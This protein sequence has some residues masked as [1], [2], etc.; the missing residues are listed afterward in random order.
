MDFSD[1]GAFPK[2]RYRPVAD[3]SHQAKISSSAHWKESMHSHQA[4]KLGRCV[5]RLALAVAVIAPAIQDAEATDIDH[6]R[7][8]GVY[9]IL[10]CRGLCASETSPNVK[11][12]GHIVLFAQPLSR[13]VALR[14]DPHYLPA[15]AREEPNGCYELAVQNDS[16]YTGYAG[17]IP[18]GVTGW[19]YWHG[20][21]V[22]SLYRSPDAGYDAAM[23]PTFNGFAGR[24]ISWG[25]GAAEPSKPEAQTIV[26]RHTG[27][28]DIELCEE[29]ADRTRRRNR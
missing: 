29:W 8:D 15:R 2:V 27:D 24:G 1:V 17:I 7:A 3:L 25:A 23:R 19:R 14:L 26:A 9:E 11:V 13:E 12:K 18:Y 4:S 6:P 28:A 5:L 21:L 16:S 22:V 10:I 20:E